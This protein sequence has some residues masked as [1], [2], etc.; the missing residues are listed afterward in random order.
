MKISL[1]ATGIMVKVYNELGVIGISNEESNYNW[2]EKVR[3]YVRREVERIH[4]GLLD[5]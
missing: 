5:Q 3:V 1:D 4:V 2:R